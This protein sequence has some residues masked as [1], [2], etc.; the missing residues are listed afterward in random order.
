MTIL[1]HGRAVFQSI[2]EFVPIWKKSRL[3]VLLWEWIK[4]IIQGATSSERYFYKLECA[5]I[6]LGNAT[7]SCSG[8]RKQSSSNHTFEAGFSG[9]SISELYGTSSLFRAKYDNFWRESNSRSWRSKRDPSS[10]RR[11][12]TRV[13][14]TRS[15]A[16]SRGWRRAKGLL[17]SWGSSETSTRWC[18]S[19]W[20]SWSRA[21]QRTKALRA[22]LRFWNKNSESSKLSWNRSVQRRVSPLYNIFVPVTNRLV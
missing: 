8:I 13:W 22:G 14:R 11:S 15:S 20:R 18:S 19:T 3:N 17:R 1:N 21:T 12:W 7:R 9:A 10:T 16:C 4:Q 2:F 6:L 5:D